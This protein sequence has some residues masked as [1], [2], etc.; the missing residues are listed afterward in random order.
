M[1][2]AWAHSE[3]VKLAV[4][5][6]TGRPI[7]MLKLLTDRYHATIPASDAWFWRDAVPVRELPPGRTL[8]VEDRQPFTLHF[9]FDE[10]QG[11]SELASQPL[12]LGMFGVTVAA[13]LLSGHASVQFVRRYGD[14]HWEPSSRNNVQL[15]VVKAPALRLS[16]AESGRVTAAGNDQDC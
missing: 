16:P 14:G 11:V 12:G 2:L 13:G 8:V 1:P 3:L 15:N 5:G 4:A 10:W 7:E 6:T 9:G